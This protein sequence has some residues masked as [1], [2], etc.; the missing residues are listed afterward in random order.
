MGDIRMGM[1]MELVVVVWWWWSDRA[2]SKISYCLLSEPCVQGA[3]NARDSHE[4]VQIFTQQ[5]APCNSSAV[6]LPALRRPLSL[7]QSLRY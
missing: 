1:V 7:Q 4:F 2:L 3:I 5:I 6:F